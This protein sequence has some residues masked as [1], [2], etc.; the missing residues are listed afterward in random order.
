MTILYFLHHTKRAAQRIQHHQNSY[1]RSC[2]SSTKILVTP[3]ETVITVCD[4][5]TLWVV[6]TPR[7][8]RQRLLVDVSFWLQSKRNRSV[9][10]TDGAASYSRKTLLLPLQLLQQLQTAPTVRHATVDTDSS[11]TWRTTDESITVSSSS[12]SLNYW[13][14]RTTPGKFSVL[15]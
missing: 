14:R 9:C 1:P 13:L 10:G 5:M 11:Q 7:R 8:Q 4:I 6:E 3:L 12:T 15:L 2:P